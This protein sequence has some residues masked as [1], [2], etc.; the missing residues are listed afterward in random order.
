MSASLPR[1]AHTCRSCPRDADRYPGFT[2]RD[3]RT[4]DVAKVCSEC[5]K[6]RPMMALNALAAWLKGRPIGKDLKS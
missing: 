4:G 3:D 1:H 6:E 2:V 5:L